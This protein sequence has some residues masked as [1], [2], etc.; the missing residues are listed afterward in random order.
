MQEVETYS[1]NI[2]VAVLLLAAVLSAVAV[3]LKRA[4]RRL[5]QIAI[6]QAAIGIEK[7]I[8]VVSDPQ[9]HDFVVVTDPPYD[10]ETR[11]FVEAQSQALQALSFR[12][13]GDIEDRT[14]SALGTPAIMRA[15]VHADGT[16][17]ASAFVRPGAT[18]PDGIPGPIVK[19]LEFSS[20]NTDESFTET[21]ASDETPMLDMGPRIDM[22]RLPAGT[23]AEV[24]FQKHLARRKDAGVGVSD[25]DAAIQQAHRRQALVAAA[26]KDIPGGIT[27]AEL[28]VLNVGNDERL[29]TQVY[30][31][32]QRRAAAR[33]TQTARP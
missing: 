27:R 6:E 22:L 8:A 2:L 10:D 9:P 1:E 14:V 12:L 29:L 21:I 31:E 7:A 11:A 16:V 28:S 20:E 33:G 26:R 19:V 15:F 24:L 5:M 25:L 18:G 13:L 3:G 30:D 32:L 4:H 17:L 23:S